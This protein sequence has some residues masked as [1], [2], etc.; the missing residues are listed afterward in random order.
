MFCFMTLGLSFMIPT[1]L[2]LYAEGL[3]DDSLLMSLT[4]WVLTTADP[5]SFRAKME[6]FD[7][8]LKANRRPEGKL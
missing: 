2:A 8:D 3:G 6:A 4:G 7:T 1:G 5:A